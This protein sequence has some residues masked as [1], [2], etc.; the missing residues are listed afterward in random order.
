MQEKE[1]ERQEKV[2]TFFRKKTMTL[3]EAPNLG[4]LFSTLPIEI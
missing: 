4:K 2:Q 3:V 1:E